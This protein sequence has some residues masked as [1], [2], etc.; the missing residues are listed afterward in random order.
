MSTDSPMDEIS[1]AKSKVK[2]LE[3]EIKNID[4]GLELIKDTSGYKS[5]TDLV[6]VYDNAITYY[7]N[8]VTAYKIYI[9]TFEKNM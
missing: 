5:N 7:K 3:N 9:E 2:A 1:N 8:L 6:K 4:K